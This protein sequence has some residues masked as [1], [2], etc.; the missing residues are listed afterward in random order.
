MPLEGKLEAEKPWVFDEAVAAKFDDM[1]ER[2]IPEYETMRELTTLVASSTLDRPG[3]VVDLGCS[4]GEALA[5]LVELAGARQDLRFLGYEVSPPMVAAAEER[6]AGDDRVEI[7]FRDLRDGIPPATYPCNA[8]LSVLTMMFVPVNYRAKLLD[9]VYRSLRPG[10]VFVLVEKV[11]SSPKLDD[12]FN[13]NYHLRKT[14][15]GYTPDEIQRKR[16][17]LEG[18]LVPS[19]AASNRN[20][21]WRAGFR[22]VDA[23]WRWFNFEGLVAVR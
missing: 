19:D 9:D 10:G 8:I 20:A 22:E 1:L 14:S 13:A 7:L 12:L 15:T 4:R 6:F 18:V 23:F 2:S 17:A 16:L 5:P 3:L 11:L 21:L